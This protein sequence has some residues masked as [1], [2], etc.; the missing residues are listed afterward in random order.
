MDNA[1]LV[2][3]PYLFVPKVDERPGRNDMEVA[4]QAGK[5]EEKVGS[6]PD[7]RPPSLDSMRSRQNHLGSNWE[8]VWY[9]AQVMQT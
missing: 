3:S 5:G 8:R 7:F 2:S 1:R 9:N 6:L 4:G